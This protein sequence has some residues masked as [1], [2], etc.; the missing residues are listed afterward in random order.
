MNA[1]E[2]RFTPRHKLKIPLE[3]WNLAGS[4]D[5]VQS[6][7]SID[8]SIRGIHFSTESRFEIGTPV[9]VLLRMPEEVTGRRSPR[10][11]CRGRVVHVDGNC[12]VNGRKGV[13]VEIQYY[14]VLAI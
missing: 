11:N 4:A 13:G 12:D 3:I 7:E 1:N 14:D 6:T 2:R 10:W 8:V 5:S 9:Q